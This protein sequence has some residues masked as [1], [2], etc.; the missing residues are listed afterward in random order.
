[1]KLLDQVR[2][3]ARVRHLSIHTEECY[4]R[5]IEPFIRFHKT[6]EG[7]RH[8][9]DLGAAE[10]ELFLTHL[11]VQRHVSASTQN[12]ALAARLFLYRDVLK[13]VIGDLNATRARRTRRL[14]VV[15]SR[16]EV[17]QLLVPPSMRFPRRSPMPCSPG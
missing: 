16:E 5:W 11:A 8:P 13:S 2:S 10:V 1:M 9:K 17:S 12:Q 7:F 4:V 14:P 15:L 6:S 3:V